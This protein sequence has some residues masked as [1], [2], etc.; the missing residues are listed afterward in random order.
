MKTYL[1]LEGKLGSQP[2][3]QPC[4]RTFSHDKNSSPQKTLVPKKTEKKKGAKVPMKRTFK[5]RVIAQ[6]MPANSTLPE[7]LTLPAEPNPTVVNTMART[8]MPVAKLAAMATMSIPVTV[9]NLAQGK[10]QE[11]LYPTGKPQ[12]EEGP[13]V[14]SCNNPQ[15]KQQ[16]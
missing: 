4:T 16:P 7:N 12:E 8:Q 11:I 14:P 1:E 3:L 13:S 15:E 6:P 9:Y 10:L 5:M 2:Q